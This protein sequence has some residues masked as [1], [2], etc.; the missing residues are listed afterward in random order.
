MVARPMRQRSPTCRREAPVL[1]VAAY[2]RPRDRGDRRW[3]HQHRVGS[4]SSAASRWRRGRAPTRARRER[5]AAGQHRS[6]DCSTEDRWARAAGIEVAWRASSRPSRPPSRSSPRGAASVLVARTTPRSRSPMR[7]DNPSPW[8]TIAWSMRTLPRLSRHAGDRHRPGHGDDASMSWRPTAHSLAAPSRAGLGL[9]PGGPDAR[10]P[11]S[12]RSVPL[13]LPEHA[14]GRDTIERHAER[15]GARLHRP[16]EG[17][18]AGDQRRAGG[19]GGAKPKVILTGGL[20]TTAVGTGDSRQST[21][22]TRYL[23]LRGLVRLHERGRG[24]S[25]RCRPRA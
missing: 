16:G 15:S 10:T 2:S 19:R 13:E 21:S 1:H 4:S 3:Q 14:I 8:A 6:E 12:C 20:S 7:V 25:G 22:S 9:G 11:R 23:T 17:A 24:P 5:R 18:G